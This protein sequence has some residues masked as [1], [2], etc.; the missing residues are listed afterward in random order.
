[1]GFHNSAEVTKYIGGI[2]ENAF[3]DP[4]LGPKLTETGLV[5]AFHFDDPTAADTAA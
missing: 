4:D 1:M 2:F 3:G 5:V